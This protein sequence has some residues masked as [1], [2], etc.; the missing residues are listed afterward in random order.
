ML[1]TILTVTFCAC[2]IVAPCGCSNAIKSMDDPNVNPKIRFMMATSHAREVLAD[3]GNGQTPNQL[4]YDMM[5]FTRR[6]FDE[7]TQTE[8]HLELYDFLKTSSHCG[9]QRFVIAYDDVTRKTYLRSDL[10]SNENLDSLP[11]AEPADMLGQSP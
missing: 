6:V 10:R 9:P 4:D 11:L 5:I 7:S 2:L 8:H 1:R 3:A